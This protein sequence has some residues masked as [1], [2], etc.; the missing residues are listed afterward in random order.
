VLVQVL[1]LDFLVSAVLGPE[2]GSKQQVSNQCS[3][4][5][6]SAYYSS[7]VRSLGNKTGISR[8]PPKV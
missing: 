6:R 5:I 8:K 1:V 3:H 4:E 7:T 2:V